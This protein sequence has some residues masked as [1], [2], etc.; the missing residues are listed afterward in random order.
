MLS[1]TEENY[2]KA[3]FH[4][5]FE[6]AGKE[7]AGT[8]ELAAA[9]GVKPATANDMLKR[10]KE[11]AL[12]DYE[13]YGK[14]SLSP[15]GKKQAVEVV[16]KHRLWETF[17][18]EKLS[19]SWDE[20]HEAAEQ[21]EHIQSKKLIERLDE[22]LEYPR[23]D[24]HGDAIPNALGEWEVP[25]RKTLSEVRVG[26][27]CTLVAVKDSSAA[28][29]QYVDKTGLALNSKIKIISRMDFDG[30]TEL[31]VKGTRITVSEKFTDNIFVV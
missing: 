12:I 17:L 31:E 8:N 9:L 25:E 26:K 20:V 10:L 14:I 28:F 21:L 24:P 22:F 19:F 15:S 13:K 23:F 27:V 30:T 7:E 3:L 18:Y 5:T 11:K 2:L 6:R 1:H 16:R 4:L 29:L